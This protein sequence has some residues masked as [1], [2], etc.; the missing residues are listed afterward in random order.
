METGTGWQ[1]ISPEGVA[2]VKRSLSAGRNSWQ[3]MGIKLFSDEDLERIHLATL[4]IME[5][6]GLHF[7]CEEALD[8][9][10]NGGATVDRK[11]QKVY[12]PPYIVEECINSAPQYVRLGARDP[13]HDVI[14]TPTASTSVFSVKGF[15][16]LTGR[17]VKSVHL[18]NKM[19]SMPRG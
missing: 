7:M 12:I 17:Q 19:K 15:R 10:E 6:A 1:K 4:E 13:K 18:Q 2:K 3:G 9:F 11:N 14:L 8:I 5:T 16:L